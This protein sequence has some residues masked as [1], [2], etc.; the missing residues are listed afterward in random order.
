MLAYPWALP[1]G[2]Y[3]GVLVRVPSQVN[4]CVPACPLGE[5]GSGQDLSPGPSL[6]SASPIGELAPSVLLSVKTPSSVT[7]VCIYVKKIEHDRAKQ[8][9]Y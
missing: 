4:V 6:L 7:V 1:V 5:Q 9:F 2:V 8:H 3:V